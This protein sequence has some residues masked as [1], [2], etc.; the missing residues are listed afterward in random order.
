MKMVYQE[1]DIQTVIAF[2]VK[3]YQPKES[4]EIKSFEWFFDPQK[5]AVIFKL[6]VDDE[7]AADANQAT[8]APW[9]AVEEYATLA[10]VVSLHLLEFFDKSLPYIEAV[11]ESARRAAMEVTTVRAENKNLNKQLVAFWS[12]TA[13]NFESYTE[14]LAINSSLRNEIERLTPKP[15]PTEG[16]P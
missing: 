1:V 10:R 3:N 6:F 8:D 11:A 12:A 15:A 9:I 5:G 2:W 14:M 7:L 13:R 16:R 4:D